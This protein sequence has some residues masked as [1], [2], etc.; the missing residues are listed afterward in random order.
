MCHPEALP[1]VKDKDVFFNWPSPLSLIHPDQQKS[2]HNSLAQ[3][4]DPLPA[5]YHTDKP[6]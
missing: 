5:P 1:P 4:N 3:P 6:N 2:I